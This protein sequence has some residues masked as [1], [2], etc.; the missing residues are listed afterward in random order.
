ML[1]LT[2][3]ST[4]T[5]S[6]VRSITAT[7]TLASGTSLTINRDDQNVLVLLRKPKTASANSPALVLLFN[8]TAQPV[9]LSLKADITQLG[10]RGSFLRTV[11]RSDNG[12]GTMH[13]DSMTLAPF[14]IYIGELRY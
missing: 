11:L 2:L 10:L 5:V 3:F 8:L 7:P 4:G 1:T 6:S 13:L 9:Q 14:A 12:M